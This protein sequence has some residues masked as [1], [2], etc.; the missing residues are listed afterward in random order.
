[1]SIGWPLKAMFGM[2]LIAPYPSFVIGAIKLV[3]HIKCKML[4]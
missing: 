4:K 3:G 1:M 2:L